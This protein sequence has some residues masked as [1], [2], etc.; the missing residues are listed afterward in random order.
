[1]ATLG[2]GVNVTVES[3][4]AEKQLKDFAR[5]MSTIEGQKKVFLSVEIEGADKIKSRLQS[6]IDGIKGIRFDNKGVMD[7]ILGIDDARIALKQFETELS[8]S[9]GRT[10]AAVQN[11]IGRISSYIEAYNEAINYKSD[12][13]RAGR[14]VSSQKQ[15]SQYYNSG[16][17]VRS[18]Q[19]EE[20][21][22][23]ARANGDYREQIKLLKEKASILEKIDKANRRRTPNPEIAQIRQEIDAVQKKGAKSREEMT[24]GLMRQRSIFRDLTS[25]AA[26]YVSIYTVA[27]F[28]KKIAE[29]TGYFQQQQVALEGILGS[30]SKAQ[31]VLNEIKGFAIQS[32]FQTKELVTFTKQLAAFGVNNNDLFPTVKKLADISAGLGVDMNRIILAYGQ[33]KSA[34][35]LRGQELRQF[36][37]AGIPMVQALADKF[38]ELN[39]RLVTTGEVF[40]LISERK[41]PF[42][43]V[44]SVLSDMTAEGGKFYKMQ[45]NITDTMYGQIQKL[46]DMW[47]IEMDRIGRSGNDFFMRII[48]LMQAMI[49]HGKELAISLGS[50]FAVSRVAKFITHFKALVR[51]MR[52][53]VAT[54]GGWGAI[55]TAAAG[56][57]S[58]ISVRL[59]D[60]ANRVKKAMA[61]IDASFNKETNK[62]ISGFDKLVNKL[63]SLSTNTGSKAFNEALS[64]LKAN[65][66]DYLND[67][68]IDALINQ[69]KGWD[70]I[71]ESIRAA[72]QEV[73]NYNNAMARSEKG[74]DIVNEDL[75]NEGWLGWFS[76]M[77]KI[78]NDIRNNKKGLSF[79]DKGTIFDNSVTGNAAIDYANMAIEN[80]MANKGTTSSEFKDEIKQ[81]YMEDENLRRVLLLVADDIF[82]KVQQMEGWQKYEENLKQANN[83]PLNVIKKNFETTLKEANLKYEGLWHNLTNESKESKAYT[84]P[85][86]LGKQYNPIAWNKGK[87]E[88]LA[89]TAFETAQQFLFND[90]A[91]RTSLEKTW[92]ELNAPDKETSDRVLG[93]ANALKDLSDTLGDG[94]LKDRISL[95]TKEFKNTADIATGESKQV[96]DRIKSRIESSSEA[97]YKDFMMKYRA[98]DD[99]YKAMVEKVRSDRAKAEDY[100]KTHKRDTGAHA[101]E[102]DRVKEEKK[103]LDDLF[104]NV[105]SLQ[106]KSKGGGRNKYA[107][108]RIVNFFDDVLQMITK[109]EDAAKKVAGV[110][111]WTDSM[112]DFFAALSDD[113][114][115]KEFF[116]KG[117]KPFEKF[118][119]KLG[120]YGVTEF[121]PQ[122]FDAQNIEALFKNAGW[123]EGKPFEAPDFERMY[124]SVI[125]GVAKEV[126][127]NLDNRMKNYAVGTSEYNSLESAKKSLDEFITR[128]EKNADMRWK[129]D[130]V[131]KKI[132]AAIKELRDI[133]TNVEDI[134]NRRKAFESIAGASNYIE[135]Q[136][137]VYGGGQYKR[138]DN[139]D[140]EHARLKSIL[141][142]DAGKGIASTHT[143]TA[144]GDILKAESVN[145]NSLGA[146]LA[147][148]TRLQKQMGSQ[149]VLDENGNP[150]NE[151]VSDNFKE[152]TQFVSEGVNALVDALLEEYKQLK[153]LDSDITKGAN[154]N[155]DAFRQYA[156]AIDRI[157]KAIK[158]GAIEKDSAEEIEKKITALQN[159]FEKLGGSIPQWAKTFYGDANSA[160][161]IS[162]KGYGLIQAFGGGDFESKLKNAIAKDF[163]EQSTAREE[164]HKK[165][166][167]YLDKLHQDGKINDEEFNSKVEAENLNFNNDMGNIASAASGAMAGASGTIAMIDMIIKAVYGA[168][169]GI[170]EM[171]EHTMQAAEAADHKLRLK[172]QKDGS[173]VDK[174]GNIRVDQRYYDDNNRRESTRQALE[175]VGTYNQHVMDGWEKFK[176]GDFLGSFAEIYNSI[177][178][179]IRDIANYQDTE[180]R[181]QQDELV[182]SNE[183]L[184]RSL[185]TLNHTL[186]GEAG[187]SRWRNMTE[188]VST[189]RQ[190]KANSEEMLNL[191]NE[192]K[193]GDAE[194]A[195]AYADE[196]TDAA[197]QIDDII[198]GIQEEIFG[199]ADELA[200]QLTDPLVEAFRNGEN[201]ARAWRDAVR[202]YIGDVLKEVLMTKVIAP[203]INNLLN[204]FLDGATDPRVILRKFS[205]PAAATGLRN[206]L[207]LLGNEMIE[208]FENLPKS[209][210]EMIAWNSESSVLSGGIQGITEDTAR[211]LEGLSNSMLAQLVLIQRSVL[212]IENSGFANVQTSW[213]NDM[214][215]QQKAMRLAVDSIEGILT[216]A[217]DG[218]RSLQVRME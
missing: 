162:K 187:I 65:Y 201:A 164:A 212:A 120:E 136:R 64:S 39:G 44:A 165:E 3:K 139:V 6:A 50:A 138:L 41:V 193:N 114:Y 53:A 8:K 30:A 89:K 43:M 36:T 48:K 191:E 71:A 33:V 77:K 150:T 159:M 163:S 119:K 152:S 87:Q 200:K 45:E 184:S 156:D 108:I 167:E 185:D 54:T 9:T 128:S 130:E 99:T 103:W 72:I 210:Q 111:G 19:I 145:I 100:L 113:N 12:M 57:I 218:V 112:T 15:L 172:A 38:T 132:D 146:L 197:R 208:G 214:L 140:L 213:F 149:K 92:K 91:A 104:D 34:A 17:E 37:E 61:E 28:G 21:L 82:D 135:A 25:M 151:E 102:Y 56:I 107:R 123:E 35:V 168:I 10:R 24:E 215:N 86:E 126:R 125:E 205:D 98:S 42:E 60:S 63:Q 169:K 131:Q 85:S 14:A 70:K 68:M 204:R 143:G 18:A 171:A 158:S 217:R 194:K 40:K 153:D 27:N 199:T 182:R 133:N 134:K 58:L 73:Q 84:E 178:D 157:N 175:M 51:L 209:I 1:M 74:A 115:M 55:L 46:R 207:F 67:E 195:Q 137:I 124:R 83:S 148:Q 62:M 75:A 141:G 49:K 174:N 22:S 121:L 105:Y 79:E 166:M 20:S 110:T 188:Q 76:G 81:L 117:G 116:K 129:G 189:L 173:Y 93:I 180:K 155:L 203:Q 78:L 32:P 196:M 4:Q 181:Q 202:S 176:S 101:D 26:R 88:D 90:A 183:Q 23:I 94:V 13:L 144:L 160:T 211:T 97:Q 216:G 2:V 122:G 186:Q 106:D 31:S 142:S 179:L 66:G 127:T 161:G 7:K 80:L 69:K 47:T 5:S 29:T 59:I 11:K 177:A 190:Q 109:A 170:I 96:N 198:R 154:A 118:F 192:K 52:K 95:L 147:I 16:R 206:D